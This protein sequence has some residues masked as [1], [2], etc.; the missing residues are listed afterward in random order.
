MFEN[1]F[2]EFNKAG[3]AFVLSQESIPCYG[4]VEELINFIAD[5]ILVDWQGDNREHYPEILVFSNA[6][7]YRPMVRKITA[8]TVDGQDVLWIAV[9]PHNP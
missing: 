2:Q 7:E 1:R 4:E 9:S 8:D 3:V 5:E 6:P